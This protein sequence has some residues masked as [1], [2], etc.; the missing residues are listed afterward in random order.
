MR[1]TICKKNSEEIKLYSGILESE[2][3]NICE[4][5]ADDYN[6]PIIKKPTN[7]Q[8]DK[9]DQRYSV[10]ERMEVMS[11]LKKRISVS[12]DVMSAKGNL[13]KL[14]TPM[15]KQLHEDV[16]DNYSWTLSMARRRRK[17]TPN[18]LAKQMSVAPE[19]IMAVEKGI[20]PKDFEPL[21]IKLEAFMSI[22]LLKAQHNAINFVRKNNEA[23]KKIL[24]SVEAKMNEEPKSGLLDKD[25]EEEDVE[26]KK[27]KFKL[28]LNDLVD[29]KKRREA[30][31][32]KRKAK[33]E[34][35]TMVGDDLDM[36]EIE[37]L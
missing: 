2:M 17:M 18:Q 21:F 4:A 1:C 15:K 11:G 20:L 37:E 25:A 8:L 10:R 5:C 13:V 28:T 31:I 3:V 32:A 35:E 33:E 26:I 14:R 12:D 36:V 27:D 22:K 30:R 19:I 9:L 29:I 16:L 6:V 24:A 23:E 7:N 34:E